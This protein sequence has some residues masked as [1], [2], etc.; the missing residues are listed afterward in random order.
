[1]PY[2]NEHA[3]RL[4]KPGDFAD[5][6]FRRVKGGTLYGKIAVPKTVSVIWGKLKGKSGKGDPVVAQ[7][8]RFPTSDWTA[9]KAKRWL[10]NNGVKYIKFEPAAEKKE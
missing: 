7:S 3:A 8:L 4:R 5:G 9:T 1:M 2:P 6:T 10:I